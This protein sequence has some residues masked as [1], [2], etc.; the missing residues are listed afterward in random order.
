MCWLHCDDT[1][2]NFNPLA[3]IEDNDSCVYADEFYDCD[4]HCLNDADS[5][6]VCDELEIDGCTDSSACNY[7]C[8][9]KMTTDHAPTPMSTTTATETA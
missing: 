4:G 1:A 5:D 3:T 8:G 7:D 6:G 2:C 9:C